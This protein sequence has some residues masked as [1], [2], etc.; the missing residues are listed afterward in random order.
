GQAPALVDRSIVPPE[1]ASTMRSPLLLTIGTV[2]LI[3]CESDPTQSE[4]YKQLMQDQARTESIVQA[5]DSSMNALFATLNR[6]SENLRTIRQKQGEL[7]DASTGPEMGKDMEQQVVDDLQSI[8]ALLAEN[9][10]L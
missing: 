9:K 7:G 4:Q 5:K 1:P 8:D 3:A 2:V 6:I 10:E